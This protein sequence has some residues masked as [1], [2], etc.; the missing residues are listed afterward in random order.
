MSGI[1]NGSVIEGATIRCIGCDAVFPD[2]DGPTH[3][4]MESSPGCWQ[5]YGAVLAREYSD[6]ALQAVHRLTVDAYAVQHPGR[7]SAQSIQ[8]VA[9]HL[10]SLCLVVERR[11]EPAYATRV[12]GSAVRVKGRF[13]WLTPPHTRGRVTVLDVA[14]TS[15]AHEDAVRAWAERAWGAWEE[16]H[17]VVRNWLKD[18]A[19]GMACGKA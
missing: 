9:V 8:S 7:P 3:R 1:H 18:Y 5:A 11:V 16:H 4:Y 19:E 2:I 15:G 10:M 12:M 13:V 14:N 6:G 17:S